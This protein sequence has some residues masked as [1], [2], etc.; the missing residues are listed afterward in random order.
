M[1]AKGKSILP[2]R[3]DLDEDGGRREEECEHFLLPP[4]PRV[5]VSFPRALPMLILY[6]AEK[7]GPDT[8]F[9][10]PLKETG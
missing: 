6:L 1:Y 9:H 2:T 10:F 5:L 7:C 8:C 3:V 4:P